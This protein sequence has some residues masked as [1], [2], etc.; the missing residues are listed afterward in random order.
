MTQCAYTKPHPQHSLGKAGAYQQ[1]GGVTEAERGGPSG[2]TPWWQLSKQAGG[3]W[4]LWKREQEVGEASHP[5]GEKHLHF[6]YGLKGSWE[7]VVRAGSSPLCKTP[8]CRLVTIK[9]IR[10]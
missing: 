2:F 4:E 6:L 10:S 3:E 7:W 1:C 9:E 8:R 5:T